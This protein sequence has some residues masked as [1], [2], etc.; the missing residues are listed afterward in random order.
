MCNNHQ[1]R[2]NSRDGNFQDWPGVY[3]DLSALF[4]QPEQNPTQ[5]R[6]SLF[7]LLLSF[8]GINPYPHFPDTSMTNNISPSAPSTPPPSPGARTNPSHQSSGYHAAHCNCH[9]NHQPDIIALLVSRFLKFS[10]LFT[11]CVVVFLSLLMCVTTVSLL[12]NSLLYSVAYLLLAAGLGLHLP[13]LV[14]G[15]VLYAL[16]RCTDPLFMAVI[17]LWAAHKTVIRRKPLV[18]MDFWKRRLAGLV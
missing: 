1:N 3:P 2:E 17:S 12:P 7:M 9:G 4:N 11:R 6:P 15:H 8:L 13:T 10:S 16:L 14:A 5:S 18:D